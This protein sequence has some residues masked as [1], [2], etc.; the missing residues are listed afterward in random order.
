MTSIH[1]TQ[2]LHIQ[3]LKLMQMQ[4]S[5]WIC[6]NQMQSTKFM[7]LLPLLVCSSSKNVDPPQYCSLLIHVMSM[8]A[9]SSPL[10]LFVQIFHIFVQ[11]SPPLSSMTIKG[12]RPYEI[13]AMW[14]SMDT[15]WRFCHENLLWLDAKSWTWVDGW[16]LNLHFWRTLSIDWYWHHL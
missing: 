1:H 12:P 7:S 6:T 5:T 2:A 13:C 9:L 10:Y 3:I 11:I 14:I 4:A 15:T 16:V 8:L